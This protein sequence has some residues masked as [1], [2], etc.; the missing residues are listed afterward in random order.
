MNMIFKEPLVNIIKSRVSVRTYSDRLLEEEVKEKILNY[1]D[2][3]SNPFN[4]QVKIKILETGKAG[5]SEKLGTYGV[6]KGAT[7]YLCA[8]VKESDL[9]LEAL[10]Y[11]FEKLILYLTSLG[12]GSCWLGGT[13]D[14]SEFRKALKL[15]EDELLPAI[16]PVGYPAKD[17]SITDSLFRFVSKGD[18]RKPWNDLFFNRDFTSPATVS[19]MAPYDEALEMVRLA[20][21]ASNKQPWRIIKKDNGYH[22]FEYKAAG[23]SKAFAYDIQ[24]IDMGIAACH[25][26]LYAIEKGLNGE[27]RTDRTGIGKEFDGSIYAFS[28]IGERIA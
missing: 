21:S 24:R 23:Y 14:R 3:L 10:G 8:I 11:Q 5:D 2:S 27:F 15:E 4:V 13:F 17:R 19:E 6:I 16:S 20:P 12:L 28:W 22:F 1:I 9:A 26:H 25:F 7:T 18:S